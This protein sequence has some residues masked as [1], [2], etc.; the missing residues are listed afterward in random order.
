MA[1]AI[2]ELRYRVWPWP[3]AI[4]L[5]E[6]GEGEDNTAWHLLN[7]WRYIRAVRSQDELYEL[8]FRFAKSQTMDLTKTND[9]TE[10]EPVDFDL[11]TYLILVRFLLNPDLKKSNHLKVRVLQ[12]V[13]SFCN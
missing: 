11:D 13:D 6:R 5:E 1:I 12:A 2:K 3:S 10:D 7:E 8:G 4:L 9:P